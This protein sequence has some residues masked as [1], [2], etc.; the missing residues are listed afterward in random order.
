MQTG[1]EKNCDYNL[2]NMVQGYTDKFTFELRILPGEVHAE[3]IVLAGRLF[4]AILRLCLA[5]DPKTSILKGPGLIGA[6][7]LPERER[8]HWRRKC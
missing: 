6:L 7:P 4:E 5:D 1:L 8:A 2:K 3:P